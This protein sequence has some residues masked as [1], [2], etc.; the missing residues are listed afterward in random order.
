MLNDSFSSSAKKSRNH[1]FEYG[2]ELKN[3]SGDD[4]SMKQK[5]MVDNLGKKIDFI[6][7]EIKKMKVF[8]IEEKETGHHKLT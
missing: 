6:E 1:S 8:H 4:N 2:L 3:M 5:E 7:R